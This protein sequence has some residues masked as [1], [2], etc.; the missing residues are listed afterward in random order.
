MLHLFRRCRGLLLPAALLMAG[1]SATDGAAVVPPSSGGSSGFSETAPP[2]VRHVFVIVLENKGYATTFGDNPPAPYLAKTLP[3]MGAMLTQY[4]GIGHVSL[5]NY[6]AMASGQGP[7]PVTQSDCQAYLD[8]VGTIPPLSPDG[9]AIGTGCVYPAEVKTIA[10][11]LGDAGYTW[12]NYAED[13]ALADPKSCRHP[14]VNQQDPW[15]NA[16]AD[17]QYATRH[18]PFLYFHSIIDNQPLCDANVVDLDQ[19]TSDLADVATTPNYA[20]ITPDLCSTGHDDPCANP[21]QQGGYGGID[22]FL[23]TWVP[24]ILA[25]PAFQQDGLLLVTFDESD[26]PGDATSC[27]NEPVGPDT[28]MAGVTGQGGGQVGAIVIS[29]FVKPGTVSNTP[30]NHYSML[31]SVENLFGLPYLGYAGQ[32]GLVAFGSDVY[33]LGQ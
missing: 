21:A 3:A 1:C 24:R 6:I 31:R 20:F 23:Q 22:A 27:C 33:S 11:Q 17:D 15:Q 30:Y 4:Y 16:T 32:S 9:Q 13:M 29:P 26:F 18:V 2:P 14:P 7:N 8:F 5:D 19:L 25:S 28:P 12:K 10:D